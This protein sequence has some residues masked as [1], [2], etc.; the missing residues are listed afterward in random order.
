MTSLAE[1]ESLVCFFDSVEDLKLLAATTSGRAIVPITWA[2]SHSFAR[3]SRSILRAPKEVSLVFLLE[4]YLI[5]V[6]Y[7]LVD[8]AAPSIRAVDYE[9][10]T[11][12]SISSARGSWA[13]G[14]GF[15]AIVVHIHPFI[16]LF[17]EQEDRITMID[18]AAI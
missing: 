7:L 4:I 8:L 9:C 5:V 15:A 2:R 13:G 16:E 10:L 3:V 14:T 17:M 1:V 6:L 11:G 12:A 18:V